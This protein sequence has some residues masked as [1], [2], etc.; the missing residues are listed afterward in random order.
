LPGL[1]HVVDGDAS[2][3]IA[4]ERRLKPAGYEVATYPSAEQLLDRLPD[5]GQL[6]GIDLRRRLADEGVGLPV[7]Y[8]TGK[9]NPRTR[10]AAIES[11]CIAYLTKP[12]VTKSLNEPIERASAEAA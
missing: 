9:D 10:S 6:S 11:G 2:V 4:I 5:S 3:R 12:F 7:I 8:I 1:V